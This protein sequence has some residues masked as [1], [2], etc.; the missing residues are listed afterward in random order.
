[1]KKLLFLFLMLTTASIMWANEKTPMPE[2]SYYDTGESVVV[3]ATGNGHICLYWDDMLMADGEYEAYWEIPYGE[4][5]EGEEFGIAATAQ[6]EGKEVSDYALATI[7]VPG[8]PNDPVFEQTAAPI[9]NAESEFF[10]NSYGP[11]NGYIITLDPTEDSYIYYRIGVRDGYE[12]YVFDEWMEYYEPIVLDEPGSYCIEA[13]AIADGKM[14][15]EHVSLDLYVGI[16]QGT[17]DYGK[18]VILIDRNGEENWF[19][20]LQGSDGSYTATLALDYAT[21]G[22]YRPGIDPVRQ[23]PLY[24]MIDGMRYGAADDNTEVVIG[25][26]M[27]NPLSE[28]DGNYTLPVGY[29]YAVGFYFDWENGFLVYAAQGSRLPGDPSEYADDDTLRGDADGDGAVSIAD[30]VLIVDY[31]LNPNT[32]E[33]NLVAA[34]ADLDGHVSIADIVA[35]VDYMLAATW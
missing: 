20:L 29:N 18:Y 3:T 5:P 6:E 32:T 22:G 8:K 1:M 30:I 13:Y 28:S 24:F 2:I 11:I 7:Y 4:D 17:H 21:Y 35:I 31:L 23:V 12:Y 15:S 25:N 27:A 14:E 26:L 16:N 10:Y 19:E 34:D 33:I 9:L